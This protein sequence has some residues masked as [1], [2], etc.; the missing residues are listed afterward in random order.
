MGI[1]CDPRRT[2][3][4]ISAEDLFSR[5]DKFFADNKAMKIKGT[6]IYKKFDR[7]PITL[8][9][10]QEDID[11]AREMWLRKVISKTIKNGNGKFTDRDE[12]A[13]MD[14]VQ[15]LQVSEAHAAENR[16]PSRRKERDEVVRQ[17][18]QARAEFEQ[19]LNAGAAADG[20][21][22]AVREA[23][24]RREQ[25]R[26]QAAGDAI[27]NV[28]AAVPRC[29]ACNDTGYILDGRMACEF[30]GC[31]AYQRTGRGQR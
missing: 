5:R 7:L 16:E 8:A 14:T 13:E 11:S 27:H 28:V 20:L 23:Q 19:R 30:D 31:D 24:A 15:Y 18:R 22:E 26:Q 2:P 9:E 1:L 6:A 4:S 17:I 10:V 29:G 12:W 25:R 3:L 21:R